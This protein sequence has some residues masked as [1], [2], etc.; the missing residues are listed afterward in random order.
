MQG[1]AVDSE[2]VVNGERLVQLLDAC[3]DKE[4]LTFIRAGVLMKANLEPKI[5]IFPSLLSLYDVEG[6]VDA[7]ATEYGEQQRRG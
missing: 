2:F 3:V 1:K 7:V 6:G 5:V 4:L